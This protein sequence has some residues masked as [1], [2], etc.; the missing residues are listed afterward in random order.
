MYKFS[1]RSLQ[2]FVLSANATQTVDICSYHMA[3]IHSC[4]FLQCI[5]HGIMNGGEEH[6][7]LNLV[8]KEHAAV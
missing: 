1:F 8:I 6:R 7:G 3:Y 5:Q 4:M 2:S